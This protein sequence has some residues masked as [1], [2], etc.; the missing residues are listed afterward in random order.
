MFGHLQHAAVHGQIVLSGGDD[1]V[2]PADQALLVDL[3]MMEERASRGFRGAHT[4]E[5]IG[6][7]DGAYVL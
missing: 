4:F 6:A 1:E 5:S 2:H 3:V 7:G